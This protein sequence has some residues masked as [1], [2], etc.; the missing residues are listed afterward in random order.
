MFQHTLQRVNDP[1]L[2]SE[3]YIALISLLEEER[4]ALNVGLKWSFKIICPF[5]VIGPIIAWQHQNIQ[6]KNCQTCGEFF[7]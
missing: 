2:I 1:E 3:R 7:F 5:L 4:K 6:T